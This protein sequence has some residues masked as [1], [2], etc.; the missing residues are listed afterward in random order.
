M[1]RIPLVDMRGKSPVDLLASYP[2]RARALVAAATTSFGLV[3]RAASLVAL[4]LGDRASRAW[5]A[6][7]GNPY[8]H[9]IDAMARLLGRSGA[10]VLNICFE[11]GCTSGVWNTGDGATLRRVL[12]WPFPRLGELVMV[13]HQDGPAGDFFNITWPGANGSFH[14]MAPGRFAAAIN[15]APMRRH[16]RSFA[17]DWLSNRIEAR[18][19]TGWPAAH[20]LRHVFETAP[21][22][23][24]AKTML[25][26]TPLAVPALFILSGVKA[27]EGCVIERVEGDHAVREIESGRVC[28][29]NH[30]ET[31][32]DGPNWEARP[33][34]S[35]GRAASA[36]ALGSEIAGF[37]W[38]TAPIA[39]INSRLAFNADA[40]AGTLSLMGTA[41]TQRVTDIFA[42]G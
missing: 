9:E 11:W 2:E 41:G 8:A 36:R 6:R 13:V 38:F 21:D 22:Y 40:G 7:S 34:D 19:A 23:A 1:E 16:G 37:D 32:L 24:A 30:F 39:N 12:D 5:L 26:E 15:Q 10:H 20:L 35:H 3:S 25:C 33:I 18:R 17:G 42:L 29:A 31:R 28:T 4:P 14:A 27:N